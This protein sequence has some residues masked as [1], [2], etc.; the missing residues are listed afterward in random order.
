[1][2][3]YKNSE[4]KPPIM[5]GT[6]V[7]PEWRIT[8]QNWDSPPWNRWSFQNVRQIL[9]TA[10]VHAARNAPAELE[11]DPKELADVTFTAWDGSDMSVEKMLDETYT[12]GFVVVVDGKIVVERYF[13]A[14]TPQTLHLAQSVS[15]SVVST[16]AGIL[17]GRGLMDPTKPISD[18]LPEL[19]NT[20]WNGALLQHVLDMTSGVKFG[21]QYTAP[22]S[23]IAKTDIAAGWK[24]MRAD[25]ADWPTC[26][27]DQ[28]TGLKETDAAHGARFEYRSIETDVLAHA[29]ERVTGTRLAELV[30]RELWSK[31]GAEEDACFTVD[32]AGYALAD[33]GFNATLRDFARFGL[34]HLN[35]G[36]VGD[37]QI[38]PADWIA[39]IR[40]GPHGLFNDTSR[41]LLPNGQYRNQFWVEDASRQTVMCVGVFGQ[42][43]YIAPEYNM[44]AVKLSTW[45]DFLSNE[46]K[47]NTLRGLHGI[48]AGLGKS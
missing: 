40:R 41:E 9:P 46:F 32:S 21:E 28:I 44:V 7:P 43:I 11:S 22:D 6:P 27:W 38:V 33:G 34:M 15:K 31:I 42:L 8:H 12:D 35:N 36:K 20:G 10:P 26:I 13:N 14:M 39:D 4:P 24:P 17:I 3:S 18:Y 25:T 5:Q 29:L 1:M 47:S 16:V 48:A 45:P 23:D 2:T 19:K 30:S 37:E